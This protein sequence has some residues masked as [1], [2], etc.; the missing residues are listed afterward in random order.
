MEL[1]K[2]TEPVDPPQP[3]G[4]SPAAGWET[5]D[6]SLLGDQDVARTWELKAKLCWSRNDDGPLNKFRWLIWDRYGV[7]RPPSRVEQRSMP[8][9]QTDTSPIAPTLHL[10]TSEGGAA[11][12][13]QSLDRDA[14]MGA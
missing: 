7:G 14:Q 13:I 4:A 1:A 3:L 2:R 10:V 12:G 5:A 6:D 9:G 11:G 8:R